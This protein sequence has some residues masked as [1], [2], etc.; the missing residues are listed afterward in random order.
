MIKDFIERI[1]IM[2]CIMLLVVLSIII[3]SEYHFLQGDKLEG[4]FIAFWAPTILGFMNYLK[5]KK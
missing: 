5:Y 1:G 2:N 4:I 3:V